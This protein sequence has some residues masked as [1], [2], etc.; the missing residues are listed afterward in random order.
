MNQPFTR[1]DFKNEDTLSDLLVSTE[2]TA[3]EIRDGLVARIKNGEK[4]VA[5]IAGFPSCSFVLRSSLDPQL[6]GQSA[7]DNLVAIPIA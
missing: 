3:V 2:T 6:K 7:G 1:I 5:A 4:L